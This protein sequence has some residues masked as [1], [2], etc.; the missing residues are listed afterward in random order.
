VERSAWTDERIDERM[1]AIDAT[2][3]RLDK[4]MDSIE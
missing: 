1:A 2:L 3:A 4:R